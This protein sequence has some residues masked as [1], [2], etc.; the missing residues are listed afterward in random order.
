MINSVFCSINDAPIHIFEHKDRC[1]I[2]VPRELIDLV[3]V[4]CLDCGLPNVVGPDIKFSIK[5]ALNV[6]V[7]TAL[8]KEPRCQT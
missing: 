7:N 2:Q 6:E 8:E 5:H 1:V 3:D 4:V